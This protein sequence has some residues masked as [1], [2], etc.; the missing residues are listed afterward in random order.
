MVLGWIWFWALRLPQHNLVGFSLIILGALIVR[1]W[2][3]N[4]IKKGGRQQQ[5]E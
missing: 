4:E 2:F 3:L 1:G 5:D